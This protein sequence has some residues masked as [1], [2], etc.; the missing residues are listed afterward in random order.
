MEQEKANSGKQN[1]DS[2]Q[3]PRSFGIYPLSYACKYLAGPFVREQLRRFND[4]WIEKDWS[5]FNEDYER[6]AILSS[7]QWEIYDR[8]NDYLATRS[9]KS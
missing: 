1:R 3:R 8:L 7:E 9:P 5:V 6:A 4:S 2:D